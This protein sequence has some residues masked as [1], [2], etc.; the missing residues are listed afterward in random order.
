[1]LKRY[2]FLS[3]DTAA[4]DFSSADWKIRLVAVSSL[5]IGF[6]AVQDTMLFLSI[7]TAKLKRLRS[8]F[9]VVQD[10]VLFWCIFAA[11]LKRLS[12]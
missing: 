1:M 4:V 2:F 10:M 6:V 5:L 7:F 12:R 9:R 8:G 3:I 11:T